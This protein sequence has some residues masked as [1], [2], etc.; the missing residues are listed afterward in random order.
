[1]R[2]GRFPSEEESFFTAEAQR[3]RR[4]PATVSA[5]ALA[6]GCT[7][8]PEPDGDSAGEGP[9]FYSVARKD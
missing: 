6:G 4:K 1:V 2:A 7:P 8:A 5:I 3:P 9:G